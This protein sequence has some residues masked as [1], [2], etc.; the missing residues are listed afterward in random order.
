M[1]EIPDRIY[2]Q[3]H[4]EFG[5]E[6]EERTWC[7]D[8]IYATDIMYIRASVGGLRFGSLKKGKSDG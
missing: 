4:D 8:R 7:E 2:L 5:E 1:K 3:I 6:L